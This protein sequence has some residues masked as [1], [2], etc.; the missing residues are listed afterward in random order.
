MLRIWEDYSEKPVLLLLQQE[1]DLE[2]VEMPQIA[3]QQTPP[4]QSVDS[5]ETGWDRPVVPLK[6]VVLAFS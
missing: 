6:N 4:K 1:F 5:S 3:P 2:L